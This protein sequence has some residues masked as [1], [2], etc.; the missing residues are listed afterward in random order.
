MPARRDPGTKAESRLAR[1][2][3]ARGVTQEELA[4]AIGVSLPTY[5]RLER[6]QTGNPGLRY[7]MN[8]ALAL[9]A[10]LDML[11]E[12]EWREW[13]VFDQERPAPPAPDEFWRRPYQP[14]DSALG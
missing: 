3:M 6:K 8:A 2:R 5:R 11:I 7:L 1:A 10:D 4:D 12:D 9:G 13:M 14:S